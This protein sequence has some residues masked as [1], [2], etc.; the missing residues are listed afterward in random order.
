MSLCHDNFAD[1]IKKKTRE[2]NTRRRKDKDASGRRS[3]HQ[4]LPV[5][6]LGCMHSSGIQQYAY[7]TSSAAATAVRGCWYFPAGG[8]AIASRAVVFII[9]ISIDV[10]MSIITSKILM[11]L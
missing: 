3:Q 9:E 8:I 1:G 2:E 4:R 10:L 11:Y 5:R 7:H 6:V